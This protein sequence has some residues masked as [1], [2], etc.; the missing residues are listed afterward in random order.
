M[1]K[2][3]THADDDPSSKPTHHQHCLYLL[4]EAERMID[5]TA[6]EW[7]P[8]ETASVKSRLMQIAEKLTRARTLSR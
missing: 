5:R 1:P 6:A 8:E 2:R 3:R 7:R 4:A